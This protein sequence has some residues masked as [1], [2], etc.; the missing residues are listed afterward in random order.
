MQGLFNQYDTNA[1]ENTEMNST[2]GSAQMLMLQLL[3]SI[4]EIIDRSQEMT[5]V[6]QTYYYTV[7]Q[8]H[9]GVSY[10]YFYTSNSGFI[11]FFFKK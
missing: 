3:G 1:Y 2:W 10:S 9:S 7:V 6:Q 8:F 4:H 5:Q 11:L